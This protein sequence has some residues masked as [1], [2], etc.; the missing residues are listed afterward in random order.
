MGASHENVA[1]TVELESAFLGSSIICLKVSEVG[2]RGEREGGRGKVGRQGDSVVWR[3]RLS[4]VPRETKE[5]STL[6]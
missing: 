6:L 3:A 5:M 4:R 2:E 1:V